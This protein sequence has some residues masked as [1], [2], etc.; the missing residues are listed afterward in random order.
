VQGL[1]L[2]QLC[3]LPVGEPCADVVGD[4]LRINDAAARYARGKHLLHVDGQLCGLRVGVRAFTGES[5]ELVLADEWPTDAALPGNSDANPAHDT[6][7]IY[8]FKQTPGY[9]VRVTSV[10]PEDGL[11]GAAV[12]VVPE[13][14]EFWNYVLTGD[15]VPPPNDSSLQTRPV[16]SNLRITEHQVVQGDTVLLSGAAGLWPITLAEANGSNFHIGSQELSLISTEG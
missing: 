11:K 13:G 3:R 12:R 10:Q 7:W 2:G 15:Y 5:R 14:Q 4:Y 8:D 16:A 1:L 6:L 9:R